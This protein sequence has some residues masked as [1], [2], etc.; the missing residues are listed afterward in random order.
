[1]SQVVEP[2]VGGWT[3][4]DLV[5]RFGAIPLNRIR[6]EP[7]PGTAAE[8]DVFEINGAR[9]G[10]SNWSMALWWRKPREPMNPIWRLSLPIFFGISS[11]GITWAS[12]WERTE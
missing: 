7:A 10:S 4:A 1:M 12:F 11:S 3:A 5:E 6:Q 2:T 8:R 9:T